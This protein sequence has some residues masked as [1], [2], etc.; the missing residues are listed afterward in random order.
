MIRPPPY[1]IEG[2]LKAGQPTKDISFATHS[3]KEFLELA[4]WL[5]ETRNAQLSMDNAPTPP[6][7]TVIGLVHFWINGGAQ[8][9]TMP[10]TY[11]AALMATDA[12][13]AA[14]GIELPWP[15]FEIAVP[16]DLLFSSHGPVRSIMI[17][18]M[19]PGITVAK[20]Y[21]DHRYAIGY[22]DD[23]SWG[24]N[25]FRDFNHMLD[26]SAMEES[27]CD[28]DKDIPVGLVGDYDADHEFRL[29]KMVVRLLIGTV[30]T[31]NQARE[32]DP[33]AYPRRPL[34]TKHG[35]VKPNTTPIGRV[36]ELDCRPQ[37]R[38]YITGR[39]PHEVNVS[40]IVRGHWRQ[41]P[42][43]TQKKLRRLQ[44]I[45]PFNRGHGPLVMR[46]VHIGGKE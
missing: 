25:T 28:S 23:I 16:H 37:I 19:P 45:K 4:H 40:T 31:I 43:G 12:K 34:R 6:D 7:R 22:I 29:W 42:H 27:W 8:T 1:V 36:L 17:C 44:W 10:H 18:E 21:T 15:S 30:L 9:I 35:V 46:P 38:D 14:E 32:T 5:G 33:N 20:K 26:D 13:G 24:V 11:A 2:A 41:Q 3:R 39:R